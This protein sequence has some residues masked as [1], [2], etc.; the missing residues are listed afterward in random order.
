VSDD[1]VGVG[2]AAR[3][4]GLINLGERARRHGGNFVVRSASGRGTHLVWTASLV[5]ESDSSSSLD[6]DDG[7]GPIDEVL[8]RTGIVAGQALSASSLDADGDI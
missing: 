6:G 1:G 5:A 2:S 7:D 8:I 4:G 3:R